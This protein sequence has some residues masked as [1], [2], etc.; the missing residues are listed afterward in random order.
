MIWSK[1][2]VIGSVSLPELSDGPHTLSV[3]VEAHW[4]GGAVLG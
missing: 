4:G 1:N 2:R 3:Y